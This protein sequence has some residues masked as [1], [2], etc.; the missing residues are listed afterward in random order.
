MTDST[1]T[2]AERRRMKESWHDILQHRVNE[3]TLVDPSIAEVTAITLSVLEKRVVS[4]LGL[5]GLDLLTHDLSEGKYRISFHDW[6]GLILGVSDGLP[7]TRTETT[8]EDGQRLPFLTADIALLEDEEMAQELRNLSQATTPARDFKDP[9]ECWKFYEELEVGAG[10]ILR[11]GEVLSPFHAFIHTV[12]FGI[13]RRSHLADQNAQSAPSVFD[14]VVED[15]KEN[16]EEPHWSFKLLVGLTCYTFTCYSARL[17]RHFLE[18][19]LRMRLCQQP[20]N[21]TRH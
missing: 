10:T 6:Y 2:I 4:D 3:M 14:V 5:L 16:G 19:G 21:A 1:G 13:L 12:P 8:E 20:I 11:D 9:E 15:G 17:N 18:L 7:L